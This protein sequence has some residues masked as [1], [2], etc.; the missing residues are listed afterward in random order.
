MQVFIFAFKPIY[1]VNPAKSVK[2]AIFFRYCSMSKETKENKCTA[3]F[4]LL[5]VHT[6]T[7]Q[8]F[9]ND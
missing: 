9:T 2:D 6:N 5:Q 1:T 8:I 3:K 4:Y 7:S